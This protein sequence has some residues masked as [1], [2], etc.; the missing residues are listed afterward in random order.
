M[1]QS[2]IKALPSRY[3]PLVGLFGDGA[4]T[5]F[6]KQEDDLREIARLINQGN[7]AFQGKLQFVYSPTESG[8]GKTTF[9]H[10][11]DLFLHDLVDSVIRVTNDN[12]HA[13]NGI[14]ETIRN[15]RVTEKIKIFNLD[16]HE[17]FIFEDKEY[18]N[19]AVQLN[20]L[21]RNRRDLIILWPVNDLSFAEK[22]VSIL[23]SV[24][25]N[26]PFG[27]HPIHRMKGLSSEQFS[28]VL[29]GILK[30]ANWQLEDAALDWD[31]VERVTDGSKNIGEYLDRVQA[32]IAERFNVDEIGFEP[33]QLIFA[34]SSGKKE[35]REICRNVR[36]ADSFY[37][38]G[39]RLLMYTKRSNV[40]EW[41]KERNSELK[42]SLPYVIAL[43]NTQLTSLSGSAVVHAVHNFGSDELS[44]FIVGVQK[45]L[46]NAQNVIKSTELY[47]Y[48]IGEGADT[49]EYGKPA[50][51]ETIDSYYK[52]QESS[53]DKHKEINSAIM[54]L[55]EKAGGGFSNARYESLEGINKGLQV[56]VVAELN[57]NSCLIE[58]H[59]KSEAET[60]DNKVSIYIL[61]KLK[62]YAINYG[63]TKP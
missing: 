31:L 26:S 28:S 40:A 54:Q 9:V 42:T 45:N 49:R 62:E 3:E 29:S 1:I 41:W 61:E 14:I 10:S 17:S 15:S 63:I 38:E 30:V 32:A 25:G 21:I 36:R 48:S 43:F 6:V 53:K 27:N 59:H 39:S 34:L 22:I 13:L 16:G 33:P 11:L 7:S 37:I 18:R 35:V 51:D 44:S 60:V 57:Y 52:I 24:G 58:F 46:G 56:D 47:K 5:T 4:K 12:S 23:K 55:I 20:T 19:F 8:A 50:K 2:S